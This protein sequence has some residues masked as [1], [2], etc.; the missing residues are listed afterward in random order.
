[1][2]ATHNTSA[3]PPAN[4]DATGRQVMVVEDEPFVRRLTARL[5]LKA[6]YAV[7]ETKDGLEA[8]DFVQAAPVVAAQTASRD[9]VVPSGTTVV[10][11]L[12]APLVA[13]TP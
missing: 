2:T 4:E 10:F 3:A 13:A 6:S 9:V 5:L 1:V 11:T 8:L 12:A 7:H